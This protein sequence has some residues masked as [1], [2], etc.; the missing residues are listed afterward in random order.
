MDIEVDPRV[1]WGLIQG[2]PRFADPF[3]E[4][5]GY[6][7]VEAEEGSNPGPLLARYRDKLGYAAAN[8]NALIQGAFRPEFLAFSGVDR[9]AVSSPEEMC[10]RLVFDSFVLNA[11]DAS[12]GSCLTNEAF[13]FGHFIECW[14]DCDWRLS[15]WRIC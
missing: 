7:I 10:R 14:W 9:R 6:A 13:L 3:G 8:A 4:P 11:R 5:A 15:F 2:N 12:V 1:V